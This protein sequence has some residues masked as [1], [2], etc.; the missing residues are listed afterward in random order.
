MGIGLCLT[1]SLGTSES[2]RVNKT[3]PAL[4]RLH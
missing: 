4:I 2:E 3:E 1:N